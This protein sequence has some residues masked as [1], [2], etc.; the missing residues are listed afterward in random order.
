MTDRTV[1][2]VSNALEFIAPR[3]V[4]KGWKAILPAKPHGW[5]YWSNIHRVGKDE[6]LPR[7]VPP[8]GIPTINVVHHAKLGG[9][10]LHN[11]NLRSSN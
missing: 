10:L 3:Y 4:P 6:L 2:T 7:Y 9:I 1:Q 11:K 5:T 8:G